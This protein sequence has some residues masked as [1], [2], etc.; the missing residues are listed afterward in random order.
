MQN[1]ARAPSYTKTTSR[2]APDQNV[3]IS[4]S[5]DLMDSKSYV[6]SPFSDSNELSIQP[7]AGTSQEGE[8]G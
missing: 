7:I 2:G 3:R 8:L 1:K 5:M 6:A 4:L